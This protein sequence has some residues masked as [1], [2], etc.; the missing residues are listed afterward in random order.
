MA[1]KTVRAEREQAIRDA[2]GTGESQTA[3]ANRIGCSQTTVHVVMKRLRREGVKYTPK[4]HSPET[5]ANAAKLSATTRNLERPLVDPA[6]ADRL[7][8]A[9]ESAYLQACEAFRT[10]YRRPF[11]TA[12]EYLYV[13]K[14]LGY[15]R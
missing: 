15:H 6:V 14:S 1:S 3:I 12:C 9:D 2:M 4:P 11:L 5:K 10:R 13:L 8:D 7:Y